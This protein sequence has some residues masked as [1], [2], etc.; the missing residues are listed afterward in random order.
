MGELLSAPPGRPPGPPASTPPLH[1]RLAAVLTAWPATA[2]DRM[3]ESRRSGDGAP[4]AQPTSGTYRRTGR[5]G[6]RWRPR[7]AAPTSCTTASATT[8]TLTASTSSTQCS[9]SCPRVRPSA[10]PATMRVLLVTAPACMESLLLVRPHLPGAGS[11]S[12][13]RQCR[14][15]PGMRK[16]PQAR[17]AAA[18][19][20]AS[21]A[22]QS[23]TWRRRWTTRQR[24]R[25]CQRRSRPRS[26]R[27]CKRS[28][29]APSRGPPGS[30][31]GRQGRRPPAALAGAARP[32][33]EAGA[34]RRAGGAVLPADRARLPHA[35]PAEH[36][37]DHG[38][39]ARPGHGAAHRV[40][41]QLLPAAPHRRGP[42]RP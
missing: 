1:A 17:L 28:V 31:P 4:R 32:I 21:R 42:R 11:M 35:H 23:G 12:G 10:A 18:K 30:A 41:A 16:P 26:S 20:E 13:A 14:D 19:P 25:R 29:R 33:N 5:R 22:A 24:L 8:W 15:C 37:G 27:S 34:G 2:A 9:A 40:H 38:P 3:H 39:L 36:D 7:R 6:G